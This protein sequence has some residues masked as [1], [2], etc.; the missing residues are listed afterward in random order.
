MNIG[1]I[2]SREVAT[3]GAEDSVEEAAEMMRRLNV[4]TL[5][6]TESQG[7]HAV[8][9][10]IVTDRDLVMEVMAK[11]VEPDSVTVGEIMSNEL[12][13]AEEGDDLSDILDAMRDECVRRVPVTDGDGALV[14]VLALDD[15]LCLY[16]RD[17]ERMAGIVGSQRLV[18]SRHS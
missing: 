5:V 3:I 2:C 13:V 14:G 15:V 7:E 17:M 18:G 9:V 11:G 8:I 6:V 1:D 12:V 10:G 16:A 4:G